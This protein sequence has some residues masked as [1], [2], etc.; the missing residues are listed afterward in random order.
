M[1]KVC[2]RR[3]RA[4]SLHC[5]PDFNC[6]NV[7]LH[8]I[9]YLIKFVFLSGCCSSLCVTYMLVCVLQAAGVYKPTEGGHRETKK[10]VSQE[11]ASFSQ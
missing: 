4:F 1:Q 6:I 5:N 11:E 10:V 8:K 9:A 3:R 7:P 2:E